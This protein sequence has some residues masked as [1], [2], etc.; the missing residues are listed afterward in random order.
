MGLFHR[1]SVATVDNR[2]TMEYVHKVS[3]IVRGVA[4]QTRPI[5]SR[6]MLPLELK[7]RRIFFRAK[8]MCMKK[9]SAL[10]Q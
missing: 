5:W 3:S 9:S 8:E 4:L 10:L 7:M 2:P 6:R 1:G